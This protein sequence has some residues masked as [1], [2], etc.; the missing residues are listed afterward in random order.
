MPATAELT[1]KSKRNLSLKK[2]F[3]LSF[4]DDDDDE[5]FILGSAV[6]ADLDGGN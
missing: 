3:C 6:C 1:E 2:K 5:Y 4:S